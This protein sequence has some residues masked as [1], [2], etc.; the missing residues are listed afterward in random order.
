MFLNEKLSFDE[1]LQ[2]IANK[3]NKSGGHLCK[4]QKLL[5]RRSLVTI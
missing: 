1:H 4:L 3:F 5:P 2:Y